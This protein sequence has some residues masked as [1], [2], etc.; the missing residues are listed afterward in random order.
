MIFK[1]LYIL[2]YFFITL[3]SSLIL[4]SADVITT[5]KTRTIEGFGQGPTRNEA[6]NNAL[7]EAMGQLNGISISKRIVVDDSSI[8]SSSGDKS[9]YKYSS[10]IK[11]LTKG[12][13]DSYKILEVE[14]ISDVRYEAT[15]EITKTTHKVSFKSPGISHK[16]RR[17]IAIMPF[18][19]SKNSFMIGNERYSGSE[20]SDM[21]S[22]SLTNTI[23]QSRRFAVV[24]R[25]Y[26]YDMQKELGII[27]SGQTSVRQKVKLGKKLSADYLL[28]GN[29]R[30]ANMRTQTSHN[31]L[32]GSTNSQKI[33]EFII[34][35]RIIVV[36][37]SQIKW[38]DTE[39]VIIDLSQA[40]GSNEMIIS[41]A[42]DNIAQS[43]SYKI[44]SNIYP[45]RIVEVT[46]MGM[47]VLNQG[48][49]SIKLGDIMNV[50]KLGKKIIDPYTKES[51]GRMETKVASIRI[52]KVTPKISYAEVEKGTLSLIK[53]G[54]LCKQLTSSYTK[55]IDKLQDNK[56]WRS[57]TVEVQDTGGVR[58]PFD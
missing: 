18:H 40:Q 10:K 9:S 26:V 45:V 52:T 42:I 47:L 24:D 21:L 20:I 25:T 54:Y 56:D 51:L 27:T 50:M 28:V 37:T 7:V 3:I 16:S 33:A 43:I 14:Q 53:K 23:T 11:K 35:Y 17:K 22:Q 1:S 38:S 15:I 48:G 29:V 6:I 36:G 46:R 31:Q 39:K 4:L 44:L 41:I 57:A 5:T 34:D 30:S 58:L 49:N 8:E 2:K 32:V 12:K 19:I 13:V 55:T